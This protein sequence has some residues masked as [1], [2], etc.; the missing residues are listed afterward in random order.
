MNAAIY[1]LVHQYVNRIKNIFSKPLPAILTIIAL[2]S[3]LS[4]PVIS[5]FIPFKGIVGEQGR[6]IVIAGV[7]LFI[8][9]TYIISAL[10]QQGALFTYSEANLLFSAPLTKR[11]I[12]MYSAVQSGPA[13]VLTAL[14]MCFYLPMI[15]GSSM[16]ALKLLATLLVM[17][18]MMFCIFIIY[19][20]IYIQDI[21]WPGLKKRLKKAAWIIF[22][23]LAAIFAVVWLISGWD[24]KAAAIS[25]FTSPWYNAVPIFGWAKWAVVA[26]LNGQ[27][28]TGFLPG[29]LLLSGLAYM[30]ARVYFS[31]EVD[32]YEKAQLDSI[33]IK[34]MLDDV[35]SN[36]YSTSG[37]SVRKVHKARGRFRPGAAAILSR[38]QLEMSKKGP[39][40]VMKELIIG[41]IYILMGLA[42]GLG[43]NFAYAMALF[44]LILGATG[45]NWNSELKKPYIYL[46]PEYSFKKVIYAVIPGFVKTLASGLIVIGAAGFLF[47]IGLFQTILYLIMTVAFTMLFIAAGVLT[48]RILGRMTNT[49]A[50]VFLRMLF[51]IFSVI[52]GAILIGILYLVTGTIDLPVIV[53]ALTLVNIAIAMLLLFLSRKLFEQSELMN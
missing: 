16:T 11:T 40:I 2:L 37:L 34:Q 19:Y 24:I 38:Q 25:F 44:S 43:F 28:L 10:S 20:Y 52:P 22:A 1:V 39:L 23:A 3:F 21:A 12:L 45:D 6:E 14:F 26:L 5:F 47:G 13:S 51:M 29:F 48:Y 4:G 41:G 42:M 46:I 8:G 33:R 18:L 7:Q 31:L 17:S 32:F 35:R 15:L 53:T 9:V 27:Y 49:I 36:G 50:L 30:L